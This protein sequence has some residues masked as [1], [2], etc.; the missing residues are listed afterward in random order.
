[1]KS[2]LPKDL[3]YSGPNYAPVVFSKTSFGTRAHVVMMAAL[4]LAMALPCLASDRSFRAHGLFSDHMILQR[5]TPIAV[6]GFGGQ[7]GDPI[8]VSLAGQVGKGVVEQD[9][10]KVILPPL[11]E[12]GPHELVIRGSSILTFRDVLIG[13]VWLATGQSNMHMRL[14]FMPEYKDAPNSF[15]NP[16][17][18]LFKVAVE[19]ATNPQADVVRDKVFTS[20]WGLADPTNS[21]EISAVGWYFADKTQRDTQVPVGLI[22]AAQGSTRTEAWMDEKTVRSI[23]PEERTF[24]NLKDP[25]NP[26]VFYNAMIAPLTGFPI[27]GFLW[28][29]GESQGH[30]PYGYSEILH[31]LIRSRRAAWGKLSLPFYLAQIHS[32]AFTTDSTGE[33]W[34]WVREAQ[35]EVSSTEPNVG[36]VPTHD[37]GEYEDIHPR[38][39]KE[40]GLRLA[41]LSLAD[42]RGA[43]HEAEGPQLTSVKNADGRLV[44]TFTN[45]M[46]G[47]QALEVVMNKKK[48]LAPTQDPAAFRVAAGT[49]TGFT[50]ADVGGRYR[51]AHAEI[52]GDQV[53]VWN[54]EIK[55]PVSVRY[56]WSNFTLANLANAHGFL[57]APFRTDTQPMPEALKKTPYWARL[58]DKTTT[59]AKDSNDLDPK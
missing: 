32:Y 25:K 9:G 21:G 5:N 39:K 22:H 41:A 44:L 1:M 57:A 3:I 28:Y 19:T 11:K 8:E 52:R 17:V 46:G 49:L 15:N 56:G 20:G 51:E 12:G 16:S 40:I 58:R 59:S 29:Q 26:W 54:E 48:G 38:R 50:I 27:A 33:A 18:R 53:L 4:F 42:R 30:C 23:S 14:R 47:L 34:A 55:D 13:D 43:R 36:I 24:T 2:M 7:V 10:W 31:G 35:K 37:L 45:T 6:Y